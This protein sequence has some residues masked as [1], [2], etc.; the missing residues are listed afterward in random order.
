MMDAT[1]EGTQ[2]K[3]S[4]RQL[5]DEMITFFVAGYETTANALTWTLYLLAQHPDIAAKMRAE[6]Q[7]V[8]DHSLP[9]YPALQQLTYARQVIANAQALKF[10]PSSNVSRFSHSTRLVSCSTSDTPSTP[11]IREMI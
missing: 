8:N 7:A 6:V 10:V 3:M 2:E 4:E 5:L 1:Y 11:G 9:A